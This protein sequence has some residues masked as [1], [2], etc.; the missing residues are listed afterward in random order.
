MNPEKFEENPHNYSIIRIFC[1]ILCTL[2]SQVSF[3]SIE[4]GGVCVWWG[5]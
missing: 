3:E 5:V 2:M 4:V 1:N